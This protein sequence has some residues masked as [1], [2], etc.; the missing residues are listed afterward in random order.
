MRD[1]Y[2]PPPARLTLDS[3]DSPPLL[4]TGRDM[5]WLGVLVGLCFL[6]AG[7]SWT[8]E[9]LLWPTVLIGGL[10]VSLESW[11]SAMT[12]LHRHPDARAGGNWRIFLAAIAPWALGLGLATALMVGLFAATDWFR[13]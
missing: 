13:F 1:I 5:A 6:A 4:Y 3:R 2:D 9:P 8:V 11:F 10:F 7:W 12:F